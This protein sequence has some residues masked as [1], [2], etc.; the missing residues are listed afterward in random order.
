VNRSR[1][2]V[3]RS[4]KPA[5]S[6]KSAAPAVSRRDLQLDDDKLNAAPLPRTPATKAPVPA[7]SVPRN[8]SPQQQI[9][10]D[11]PVSIPAQ[12]KSDDPTLIRLM[13]FQLDRAKDGGVELLLTGETNSAGWRLYTTYATDRDLLQI[14]LHGERPNDF[15]AQVMSRPSIRF[16]MPDAMRVLRRVVVHGTNGSFRGEIPQ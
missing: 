6:A 10:A 15:T 9:I 8:D 11:E 5:P 7:P 12:T 16:K 14:W 1:Q 3:A 4:S 13:N 2:T